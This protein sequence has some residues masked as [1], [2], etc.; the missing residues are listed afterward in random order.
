[1]TISNSNKCTNSI[2]CECSCFFVVFYCVWSNSCVCVRKN[3]TCTDHTVSTAAR[4]RIAGS[5]STSVCVEDFQKAFGYINGDWLALKLLKAG[6]ESIKPWYSRVG[7]KAKD[8]I[9]PAMWFIRT[10]FFLASFHPRCRE[11]IRDQD[12]LGLHQGHQQRLTQVLYLC[13]VS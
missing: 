3:Q 5:Q 6:V 2:S 11:V 9:T 1:M 7:K 4:T 13:T 12:S 8:K 10:S